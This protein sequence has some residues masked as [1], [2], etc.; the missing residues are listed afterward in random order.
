MKEIFYD[1]IPWGHGDILIAGEAGVLSRLD[2]VRG[3]SEAE[4]LLLFGGQS[5]LRKAPGFLPEVQQQLRRYL[6]GEKV[7]WQVPVELPYGT[8]FQRSVWQ[9]LQKIP[10]GE[11]VTYGEL[12]G[13]LG[14]PRAMR[15]VGGANGANPVAIIIPCHR[16]VAANGKLGGYG[17]G[18]QVKR[19]LL[20]LEGNPL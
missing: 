12:A 3:R 1:V 5:T 15:A 17:G 9:E 13:R 11:T 6:A 10:W 4:L 14:K 20:R 8:A 7:Q 16:V 2:F 18:L 19:A